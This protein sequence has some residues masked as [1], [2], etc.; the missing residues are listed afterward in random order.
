M[1]TDYDYRWGS[2]LPVLIKVIGMTKGTV[3]EMG[4]GLYSTPFLHWACF[5]DRILIS[6][7]NNKECFEMNKQYRSINHHVLFES[8]WGVFDIVRCGPEVAFIDHTPSQRRLEDIKLL[9]NTAKYIIVHDT[10]RN[11]QFCDFSKVWPLFKYRY[12][13]KKVIPY[14]TVVSNFVDVSSLDI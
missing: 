11:K 6:L 12:D 9:A 13:Y 14:T 3:L 8:H 1:K 4:M 7:E 2:H 10:Q 5:P